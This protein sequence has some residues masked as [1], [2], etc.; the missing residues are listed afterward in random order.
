LA[1]VRDISYTSHT[2][3]DCP[4]YYSFTIPTVLHRVSFCMRL[5]PSL[6]IESRMVQTSASVT[7]AKVCELILVTPRS[8][9]HIETKGAHYCSRGLL[10]ESGPYATEGGCKPRTTSHD[11]SAGMTNTSDYFRGQ[12]T[13]LYI[14][15]TI[16]SY[17]RPYTTTTPCL[18]ILRRVC[19][20]LLF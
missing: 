7:K 4:P 18:Q 15:T 9:Y 20:V 12:I 3:L 10:I 14:H 19:I 2:R 5:L 17:M 16:H 8:N 11:C 6:N 1:D 13:H